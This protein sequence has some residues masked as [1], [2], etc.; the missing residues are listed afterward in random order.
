MEERGFLSRS[1]F[2]KCPLPIIHDPESFRARLCSRNGVSHHHLK[3]QGHF[4]YAHVCTGPIP[5]I[6]LHQ[7]S[8]DKGYVDRKGKRLVPT[9]K[10]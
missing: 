10:N 6:S 5:A 3:T 4:S 8:C 1:A 9:A 2:G 7:D